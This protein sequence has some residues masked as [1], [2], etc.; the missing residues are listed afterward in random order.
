MKITI[1]SGSHRPNSQSEKVAR[2]LKARVEK[3]DSAFEGFILSLAGNPLPLWD[4]EFYDRSE[5]WENLWRPFSDRLAE[6]DSFIFVV[7]EW[8]W[9]VPPAVKN[10]LL[11]CRSELAHKPALIVSV[12]SGINGVYPISELRM[13]GYKN[14]HVCFLPEHLII[15]N[16]EQV[17][18]PDH[19]NAELGEEKLRQRIDHILELLFIYTKA[20]LQIRNNEKIDLRRYPYGM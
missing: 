5:R 8:G 11:L 20:F 18:N 6:S 2:Y 10:L 4:E 9:M 14:T 13:S 15:R 3:L 16:V 19:I 12:S 1:I 17:L 7:P